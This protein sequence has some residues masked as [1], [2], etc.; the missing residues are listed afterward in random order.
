MNRILAL[1]FALALVMLCGCENV[2]YEGESSAPESIEDAYEKLEE[3]LPTLETS[4]L[5]DGTA[6]MPARQQFRIITNDS[7]VF[8]AS[9][10]RAGVINASVEERNKFLRSKYGADVIAIQKEE[11]T[12]ADELKK[13]IESGEDYADL[14]SISAKKTVNLYLSGLLYDI[15][16]LPNFNIDSEFFD[17]N[18]AKTLATNNSLYILADP[19]NLVYNE[20]Y[21]MFFNKTLIENSGAENPESLVKQGKWTWDKFLE[22]SKTAAKDVYNKSSADI[23]KDTFAYGAYYGGGTYPLIMWASAGK[24]IVGNS[25]KNPVAFSMSVDDIEKQARDLKRYYDT[26]G[27]APFEGDEALKAFKAGRLV[28]FCNKLDYLYAFRDGDGSGSNFGVLPLP[29]L[30]ESQENY[31][32]LVGNDARVFSVPNTVSKA[33]GAKKRFVSVVLSALCATGGDTVCDAYVSAHITLYFNN[34]DEAVNFR[35]ICESITFDF[36]NVYGSSIKEIRNATTAPI[37]DYID[38]GSDVSNSLNRA[39]GSFD[40]YCKEK[41]K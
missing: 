41:F 24:G 32:C 34:N 1:I 27:K 3:K 7:S 40:K 6:P 10:D 15:N 39:K 23:K 13:A 9:E 37:N 16:T 35:E 33:D 36:G 14:I 4:E 30:D 38:V 22:I 17:K 12:V 26:K 8:V 11:A 29:K 25:Y 31:H 19:T 18:N 20:T 2:S 21:A 5:P 28:F